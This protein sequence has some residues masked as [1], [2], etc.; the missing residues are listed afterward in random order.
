MK[1][2]TK[3]VIRYFGALLLLLLMGSCGF[4]N[5][6]VWLESLSCENVCD[7]I[8][9]DIPQ[10]RFSWKIKS[11][12][13]GVEQAGYQ[14]MV[15]ES[16]QGLK[17]EESL[18]WNSGEELSDKTTNVVY[19][20]ENLQSDKTYYWQVG[21]LHNKSDRVVWSKPATFHTGL[22]DSSLWKASWISSREE[23]GTRSPL[24]RKS[25]VVKKR[26]KQAFV[27]VTAA[28][29][30]ELYLNG[31]KVGKHV[32]DPAITDYR[33]TILYSAFEVSDLLKT[34]ENVTGAMLGN[35]AYNRKNDK[36]RYLWGGVNLSLG[37]PCLLM[38]L[39]ITYEDGTR[40]QIVT[41]ETWK[42]A[43]GPV[44]FNNIYGG[45]DYDA[46]QEIKGWASEGLEDTD[47]A[48][49]AVVQK[50]GG[51]LKS[52][53]IP[54]ILV[55]DTILPVK[56]INQSPG[57]YLFDLGQNIVGWWH[58]EVTGTEGVSVRVRG[59][60]TLNDLRFPK[61]LENDDRLSLKYSYHSK[62][63][64]SY[65]LSGSG[66][67][68]YEPRFFY[69]GFRYLEVTT[70]NM[71]NLDSLQL[72]GCVVRSAIERNGSF[73]SSDSLL[74]QIHRA[75]LWSQM[76]NN[77]GYPTDCPHREKG[78]YN[79][80]GQV[81]A[82][83][84]MH[85]FQ[86]AAYYTK[87]LNDM[88]DAQ[89][90]N[91]RIPNTS[92]TIM[93]G[94]GGGVAWGSAYIL[95]PWWMSNYYDDARILQ[96]H[97]PGM[98]RY[99][100]YLKALGARDENPREPYIINNFDGYWDSLGEWCA[101]GQHDG[102]N[103]PMVNTFYYFFNL[104]IM[105]QIAERLG[106]QKDSEQFSAL[107]DT[108]KSEINRK[109]FN[110]ETLLYG[111]EETY[112]TY[113]LLAL[114]GHIVPDTLRPGVVAT[115]VDD[116]RAR[117]GHLNT[118]IIGTKYL[119]PT[120]VNEGYVDLAFQMV[121]KKTYPGYGYWLENGS[122]TLLEQWDGDNSHNHQM[123]GSVVEY[124]YKYLAGIQSPMEGKTTRGY[125]HVNLQ[126]FVPEG[127]TFVEASV[128][129]VSGTIK[130]SWNRTP[131]LFQYQISVPPNCTATVNIPI[132]DFEEV[133]V[134]EKGSKIWE[135]NQWIGANSDFSDP[136]LGPDYFS[137]NVGSG[138]FSFILKRD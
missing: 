69:S 110:P 43:W 81:I 4:K 9:M 86:M 39:N 3:T 45:E 33:K 85:D 129:T 51:I 66:V 100:G 95:I 92:P 63:W 30:Y 117:D 112:Q 46:R 120:L 138:E 48:A 113:Q 25:F 54:P 75:G 137:I 107:A 88:K 128:E 134:L 42:Y 18:C 23:T 111:T 32:L 65:T 116:I 94:T 108:I 135:R 56:Q 99:L 62:V 50:P 59:A 97:Y 78:A 53:L 80:D 131:D 127:L 44:T 132:F 5:E 114:I 126:P 98:K 28:G 133:E 29:F 82:E 36:E 115:I 7:P 34:G 104:Q 20:G 76:G 16:L 74:N 70:S 22:L 118:G 58:L 125:R 31:T 72:E 27:F 136:V 19:E 101:P 35:G 121:T 26:V 103:H 10:P 17:R 64:S 68:V 60:E 89:E 1:S 21:V 77:L 38:Q 102:P 90:E 96:E 15:S 6:D 8:G 12:L 52:Q 87:W 123:F 71:E 40:E 49:V 93:G 13:R 106:K 67:E 11:D 122:T 24:L 105:S 37:N 119:W 2:L 73:L 83:T 47:W 55:T 57:V 79:G 91:G 84:S 61:P 130:S 14:I 124:F 41:D 109:F